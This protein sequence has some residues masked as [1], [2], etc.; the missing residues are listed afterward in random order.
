MADAYIVDAVRSAGGRRQ[1]RLSQIHAANLGAD[2]INGL[3][4]RVELDPNVID[5]VIVGCVTQGGEQAFS[6]ARNVILASHLPDHIPGVTIDRQCGSSQQAI[7]FAAQAVMSGTQ[8]VIIAAG[9]ESMSRVPMF[10]NIE[11][12]KQAGLAS[13]PLSDRVKARFGV[14]AFSQ[15][16]G[17][18]RLAQKYQLS[19]DDLDAYALQSHQRAQY[20]IEQQWFA[21]EIIPIQ[22][23]DGTWH[24][25]DE[26][27]RFSTTLQTIQSVQPLRAGGVITAANASQICDGASACLI[28]SES[29]LK[30]YQLVPKARIVNLTITAGDPVM[31]LEEPIFA[32]E[33]A[34]KK[35]GLKLDDI[36]LFEVNEAFASVPLAWLKA[37]E[38]EPSRVNKFGGAIA[39]GHPLGASG[40]KLMSTLLHGL[41]REKKKYGLQTMC[42]GGGMANVTI[43]E[44]Y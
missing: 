23:A 28:V 29:A 40:T 3:L 30:K 6:F 32:T 26:G 12:A 36:D 9:V 44:A 7:Q 15:F 21:D 13:D 43:I 16:D 31:M 24:S 33:R 1:G 34:V 8:D 20:A 2:V 10:S 19:R 11:L 27:V 38:V 4:A 14:N 41:Q 35:A 39:L 18:E 5:D 37:L 42:E 17:A 22:L 25:Q